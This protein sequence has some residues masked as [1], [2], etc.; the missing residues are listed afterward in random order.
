MDLC[1]ILVYSL[2]RDE[3][4]RI[5]WDKFIDVEQIAGTQVL[6]EAPVELV[7]VP[8]HDNFHM[9][10]G[11]PF[12]LMYRPLDDLTLDLSYMLLTTVRAQLTYRLTDEWKVYVRCAGM[13]TSWF[14]S[15]RVDDR[16]R[17]FSYAQ[18]VAG[19][20]KY[21]VNDHINLDLGAGYAF[22]RFFFIGKHL[23]DSENNRIDVANG[24]FLSLQ[25]SYRW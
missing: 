12:S 13:N 8:T 17:F 2:E 23:S 9:N 11:L 6:K 4:G 18:D 19:G 3:Q 7:N 22:D 14:L 21:Q 5:L 20:L 16:E 25:A 1:L 24:A 15:D 10:I